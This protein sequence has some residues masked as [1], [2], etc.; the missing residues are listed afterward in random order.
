MTLKVA[1]WNIEGRLSPLA[2][3]RRGTPEQIIREIERLNTDVVFLPEAFATGNFAEEIRQALTALGYELYATTY[4]D[5]GPVRTEI[6]VDQP[7]MLLLS[8]VPLRQR[9]TIR[10][11]DLRNAI[12]AHI[13][14]PTSRQTLRIIGVH[15]DDRSEALRLQQVPDLIRLVQSS[16]EPTVM[17]GDFNAMQYDS[18]PAK[19][20]RS[21]MMK[22][23]VPNFV[24]GLGRR[25]VEMACGETLQQL[26]AATGLRDVDP[27]FRPTTTP[28]M[29]GHEWLPSICLI[30]IDHMLLSPHMSAQ[31]FRVSPDGGSDHRAISAMITLDKVS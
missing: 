31:N 2:I 26:Q 23:V 22:F 6:A 7:S 12:V 30:G 28:K 20:L 17:L 15:L 21:P 10:L 1:S 19:L 3:N 18:A 11:G 24:P 4:D 14:D 27:A 9:K 16:D 13:H 25:V 5:G 29:R 8:R